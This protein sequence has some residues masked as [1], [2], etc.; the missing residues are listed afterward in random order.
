MVP[1]PKAKATTRLPLQNSFSKITLKMDYI[2]FST[3][4]FWGRFVDNVIFLIITDIFVFIFQ[5]IIKQF[6]WTEV[7]VYLGINIVLSLVFAALGF[8]WTKLY[9][10]GKNQ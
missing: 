2:E 7:W 6:N 9:I 5:L 3:K 1:T 10:K 4:T 8:G